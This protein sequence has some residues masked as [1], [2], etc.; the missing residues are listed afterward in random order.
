VIAIVALVA[1]VTGG[2][3]AQ[4]KG[5]FKVKV[6][7]KSIN[8]KKL[9]KSER[10]QGFFTQITTVAG[11]APGADA[12]VVGLDLPGGDFQVIA[13]VDLGGTIATPASPTRI[14]CQLRDDGRFLTGGDAT[15]VSGAFDS[16][17]TLTWFT[18][19]GRASLTCNPSFA[20]QVRDRVVS[21]TRLGNV[22]ER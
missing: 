20:A 16:T 4:S 8:A 7:N 3:Y 18:D 13:S 15:V 6:P 22:F 10:S 9:V 11:I 19:G 5:A 21:A 2:A 12:E 14:R 17:I 1:A